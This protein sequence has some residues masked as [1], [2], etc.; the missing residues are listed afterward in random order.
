LSRLKKRWKLRFADAEDIQHGFATRI[1]R[2]ALS[3]MPEFI[4]VHTF[5]CS[6]DGEII[7]DSPPIYIYQ[8][9]K[10]FAL[11]PESQGTCHAID[12]GGFMSD[13][14]IKTL[15]LFV[16]YEEFQKALDQ[17]QL[18]ALSEDGHL[19]LTKATKQ[20]R[21]GKKSWKGSA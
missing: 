7:D 21:K 5:R 20:Y 15:S 10:K 14:L 18:L 13:S 6:R 9:Q 3:V 17:E 2:V 16:T 19:L 11:A 1:T 12:N 4:Q 8:V